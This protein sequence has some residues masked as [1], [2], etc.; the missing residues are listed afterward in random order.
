MPL[1]YSYALHLPSSLIYGVHSPVRPLILL[2]IQIDKYKPNPSP[3]STSYASSSYSTFIPPTSPE[4]PPRRQPIYNPGGFGLQSHPAKGKE[5]ALDQIKKR[6]TK[7]GKDERRLEGR[8]E[9]EREPEACYVVSYSL[10]LLSW[11]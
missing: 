8:S 1:R 3:S 11:C 5:R 9:D 7:I 6:D 10:I 2:K 4:L